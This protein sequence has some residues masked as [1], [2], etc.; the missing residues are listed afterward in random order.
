MANEEQ[1]QTL[2]PRSISILQSIASRALEIANR[3]T[4]AGG[5]YLPTATAEDVSKDLSDIDSNLGDL[6]GGFDE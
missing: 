5:N 6:L 4:I 1:H 3:G 2:S